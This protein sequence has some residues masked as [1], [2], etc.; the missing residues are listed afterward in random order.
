VCVRARARA[1]V[2]EGV[3]I[4]YGYHYYQLM[5]RVD[6]FMENKRWKVTGFL[7]RLP[8]NAFGYFVLSLPVIIF[9]TIII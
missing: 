5:L 7:N 1:S 3:N 2:C 8:K 6:F 4:V 9:T